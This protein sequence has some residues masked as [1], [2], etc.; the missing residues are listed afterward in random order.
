M[1]DVFPRATR[2]RTLWELGSRP[3]ATITPRAVASST[4]FGDGR[5]QFRIERSAS[6]KVVVRFN[7][8]HESHFYSPLIKKFLPLC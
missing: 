3:A 7:E 8:H 1:T 5:H 6:F 4:S 2:M